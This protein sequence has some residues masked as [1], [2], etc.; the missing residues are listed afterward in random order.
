MRAICL[1]QL[2]KVRPALILTRAI[3]VPHMTGIT[4][5]PITSTIRGYSTEVPVDERNGL[6]QASVAN[7]AAVQT[8]PSADVL[9][10]VGVLFPD[11]ESALADAILAAFDLTPA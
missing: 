11:Q 6:D 4:V 7:C 2:D 9:G 3:A 1:V 10:Q 5:A 8:V